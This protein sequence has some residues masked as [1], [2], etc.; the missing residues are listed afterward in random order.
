MFVQFKQS[1]DDKSRIFINTNHLLFKMEYSQKKQLF[2]GVTE[3][4][5]Y[6]IDNAIAQDLVS[7]A[8]DE[9]K[10]LGKIFSFYDKKSELSL[11]NKNR[12]IIASK[13]LLEVIKKAKKY[14][15]K[16][17]DIS[18]GKTIR[19]RKLGLKEIKKGSFKDIEISNNKITLKSDIKLDLGSIAKGYIVDKIA[20]FL[21][22]QGVISGL[23]D[24]RGD[25]VVFGQEHIINIQHPRKNAYI[26]EIKLK[27]QAV[28]T[29]GDYNQFIQSYDK[30]HIINKDAISVTV[31]ADNL[32]DADLFA[33]LL[34]VSDNRTHLLD[35]RID[36]KAMVIDTNMQIQYY[37]GFE[38]L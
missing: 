35:K 14:S 26:G 20:D 25:I 12:K 31:V 8:Y 33:T 18:L 13:E 24:G 28:A 27:N 22:A 4:V 3:I 17:Y 6:D 2:G 19:Q 10:R 38:D 30:S 16:D 34:M 29:S 23:I 32:T 9:A 11:L 36:I 21:K 7:K 1:M 37:N 5:L 15:N